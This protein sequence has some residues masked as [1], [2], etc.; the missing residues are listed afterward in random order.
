MP[1]IILLGQKFLITDLPVPP[2]LAQAIGFPVS[3]NQRLAIWS[4]DGK[5]AIS[6]GFYTKVSTCP[7]WSIYLAHPFVALRLRA[8]IKQGFDLYQ[9]SP[10]AQTEWAFLLDADRLLLGRVNL[11]KHVVNQNPDDRPSWIKNATIYDWNNLEWVRKYGDW[12]GKQLA[13]F[14]KTI[15]ASLEATHEMINWLNNLA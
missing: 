14:P 12:Q 4:E 7:A 13:K 15:Q 1:N 10:Q 8:L 3:K 6:N 2:Q 11:A 9:N 5:T